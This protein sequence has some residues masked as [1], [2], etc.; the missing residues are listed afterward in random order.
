M[1]ITAT[2]LLVYRENL[3]NPEKNNKNNSKIGTK[4]LE[5]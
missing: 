2:L 3:N 5:E 1:E 4:F